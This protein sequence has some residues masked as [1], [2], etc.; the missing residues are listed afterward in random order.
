MSLTALLGAFIAVSRNSA[1][2]SAADALGG[3]WCESVLAEYDL[4]LQQR[5][6]IFG[7]YGSCRET[8]MRLDFYA[9]RDFRE[10][11]YIDYEGS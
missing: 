9:E 11:R 5:Y 4:P 2:G 3:L 1:A 7:F 10:K 8:P 6:H